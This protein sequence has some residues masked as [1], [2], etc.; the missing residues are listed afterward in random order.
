LNDPTRKMSKSEAHVRDHAVRLTDEPDVIR[1]V[2]R[3]AV[4]DTG[5]EIVFSDDPEK[6]GVN[7]LLEIYELLTGKS[8]P[9]IEA[10]FAG[11]GYAVLKREVAE[12]MIEALRP[13]RERYQEL[14]S[15]PAELDRIL[16]VGAERA[17]SVAGPKIQEIKYRVGFIPS[18]G[19]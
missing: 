14:I 6:A 12:V 4:T 2:I 9:E 16:A 1:T 13:I 3:R 17:R 19:M 10:R 5:R 15:D 7:N 8:R 11:Q 18:V